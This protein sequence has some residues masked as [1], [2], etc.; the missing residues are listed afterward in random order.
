MILNMYAHGQTPIQNT[1]RRLSQHRAKLHVALLGYA[2]QRHILRVTWRGL[3]SLRHLLGLH[4]FLW[5]AALGFDVGHAFAHRRLWL[6]VAVPA[7]VLAVALYDA[8]FYVDPKHP[9]QAS[10]LMAHRA[11][12]ACLAGL[13]GG[14]EDGGKEL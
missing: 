10:V 13:L 6:R 12:D 14:N 5:L 8:A 9:G 2:F 7:L 3:R 1:F 4:A 11:V